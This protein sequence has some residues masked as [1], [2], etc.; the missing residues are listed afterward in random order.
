MAST[1]NERNAEMFR[2]LQNATSPQ[3]RSRI[4]SAIVENNLAFVR[5]MAGRDDDAYQDGVLG[6]YNALRSFDPGRGFQ[7]MTYAGMAVQQAIRRGRERGGMGV[8][9]FPEGVHL[10]RHRIHNAR[11]YLTAKHARPATVTDIAAFLGRRAEAIDACECSGTLATSL[12]SPLADGAATTFL[13]AL[14][15]PEAEL[16]DEVCGE[17]ERR[18]LADAAVRRLDSKEGTVLRLVADGHILDDIGAQIGLSGERARQIKE[19]AIEKVRAW[20]NT[21]ATRESHMEDGRRKGAEER[22]AFAQEYLR[23]NPGASVERIVG[24]V[25][26]KFGIGVRSDQLYAM[27][28]NLGLDARRPNPAE[29]A[30]LGSELP[31]A[32]AAQRKQRKSAPRAVEA[33]NADVSKCAQQLW[34]AMRQ[35]GCSEVTVTASGKVSVVWP[36]VETFDLGRA[37]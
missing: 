12:N 27:K 7:F 13:D 19:R 24:A 5:R 20:V 11:T 8:V 32:P 37:S 18:G 14:S 21:R 4:Q 25:R 34:A 28:K 9:R 2:Q 31:S 17:K 1:H 23:A 30:A 36:R 10:T 15:D 16:A 33:A 35:A 26:Q 22:M 3:D 6:L 29:D